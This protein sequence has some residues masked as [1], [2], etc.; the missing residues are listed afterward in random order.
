MVKT[1]DIV[2]MTL[3]LLDFR[4]HNPL[5]AIT[6]R[7]N[8][9]LHTLVVPGAG[10]N[11]TL[12]ELDLHALIVQ[13]TEPFGIRLVITFVSVKP[14]LGSPYAIIGGGNIIVEMGTDPSDEPNE[15]VVTPPLGKHIVKTYLGELVLERL[16]RIVMPIYVPVKVRTVIVTFDNRHHLPAGDRGLGYL[17][18]LGTGI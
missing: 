2:F 15:T 11:L 8:V 7:V 9:I 6:H 16:A 13:H 1:T 5:C 14:F 17:K 3:T 18:F 12:H 10:R 4:Y